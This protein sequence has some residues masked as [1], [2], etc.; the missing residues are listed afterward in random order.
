MSDWSGGSLAEGLQVRNCLLD[1]LPPLFE[2]LLPVDR[3][4]L[5]LL[6]VLRQDVVDDIDIDEEAGG[7]AG[8]VVDSVAEIGV[9]HLDHERAD[10]ARRAELT[11]QRRVAQVREQVS[12][13]LLRLRVPGT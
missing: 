1:R 9:D 7:A 8:G 3:H 13:C 5:W 10:L 4:F 12:A 11:V 6:A 2:P